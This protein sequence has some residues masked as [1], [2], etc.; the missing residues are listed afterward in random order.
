MIETILTGGD[1]YE[2]AFTV[3]MELPERL[4]DVA[5]TCIGRVEAGGGVTVLDRQGRPV[6]LSVGGYRHF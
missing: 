6:T 2:L 1:D 5:V 3:P 4:A